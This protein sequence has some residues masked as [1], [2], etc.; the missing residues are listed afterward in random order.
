MPKLSNLDPMTGFRRIFS[1]DSLVEVVKAVLLSVLLF[2]ICAYVIV[3]DLSQLMMTTYATPLSFAATML[4]SA[5][6]LF[7]WTLAAFAFFTVIDILWQHYSFEKRMM[8]SHRDI[9]D[10]HRN[11]EGYPQRRRLAKKWSGEGAKMSAAK[12][13]VLVV[14]PIHVA[15]AV[16]YDE[17]Q[18]PVP[19]VIGRGEEEL[20]QEMRDAAEQAGVPVL[21][22]E[23]LAR[24]L[25]K[26]T[27][28]GDLVPRELFAIIAE[29][30]LWAQRARERIE[31]E[32]RGGKLPERLKE[33]PVPG[34]D[35]TRYA[36]TT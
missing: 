28:D 31:S 29:V 10:E 5:L 3:T 24:T 21:R 4:S 1:T 12:A 30:A 20:A 36:S 6:K 32:R 9:K 17:K 19:K 23:L 15:I 14:N 7:L 34:E 22:N 11:M 18:A 13:S 25:L 35:L 2:C 27:S 26:D 8:M 16:Y 33:L